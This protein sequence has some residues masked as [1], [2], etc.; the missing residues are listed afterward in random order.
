MYQFQKRSIR[1]I[2]YCQTSTFSF[3]FSNSHQWSMFISTHIVICYRSPDFG[4]EWLNFKKTNN[5]SVLHWTWSAHCPGLPR[6]P[7]TGWRRTRWTCRPPPR[8]ASTSRG[9]PPPPWST[10]T[11]STTTR[12]QV[13]VPTSWLARRLLFSLPLSREAVQRCFDCFAAWQIS[14]TKPIYDLEPLVPRSTFRNCNFWDE[15]KPPHCIFVFAG[16]SWRRRD[17]VDGGDARLALG[18]AGSHLLSVEGEVMMMHDGDYGGGD[19]GDCDC[20]QR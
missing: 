6:A 15:K 11:S 14:K 4:A 7:G 9:C 17:R 3:F 12:W 16:G 5:I 18:S 13:A 19:G 20:C 10:R 8:P 1:S 2:L